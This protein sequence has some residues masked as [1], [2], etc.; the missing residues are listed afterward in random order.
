MVQASQKPV[1]ITLIVC[2]LVILAAVL[3]TIPE[4]VEPVVVPTASEIAALV[5][6]PDVVIPETDRQLQQE[7]WDEIYE[8]EVDELTEDAIR[9]CTNEFDWDDVEDLFED[10]HAVRF[11]AYDDDDQDVDVINLGLDD[12]DDRKIRLSGY[13]TVSYIPDEGQ[14]TRVNDKVHGDCLVTSDDGDLEAELS[15]NL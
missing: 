13:F 15:F 11:E 7:I 10:A 9:E 4:D 14:Q 12:E 3:L 2:S 1:I 5:V 6:I 8:D